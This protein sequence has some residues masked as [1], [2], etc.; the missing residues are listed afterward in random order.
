MLCKSYKADEAKA[1]KSKKAKKLQEDMATQQFSNTED[2][3]FLKVCG[4]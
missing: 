4:H 1:S 2:E 3:L